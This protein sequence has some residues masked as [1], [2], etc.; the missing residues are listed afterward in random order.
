MLQ[1]VKIAFGTFLGRYFASIVA[2][3]KPL[4]AFVA[5]PLEKA[6]A[7]V[8]ARMIDA[9]EEMLALW[10][11]ADKDG[12]STSP[13]DMP[14]ML[15]AM[16]KDYVPT[17]RDFTRQVAD[18][19][20]VVLPGD[21]R[22]RMFGLRT[23]AGDVRA[24]IVVFATDEP[25]A[26]S[27]AAQFLLFLDATENR[28][29]V[30]RYRFA[31][32]DLDWPVQIETPENPAMSIQSDAKNLTILAVDVNLRVQIPLFDAPAPGQPNDGK[33]EPGT[34]DPAGYPLVQTVSVSSAEAGDQAGG[35]AEIRGYSVAD[36]GGS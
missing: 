26:R 22:G 12:R 2:T 9:A 32:L 19:E 25:S 5:R 33:G 20:M 24:Q 6:V 1:P 15:V 23:A 11:R 8:P 31:G 35:A 21:A 14:V 36:G 18:R 28:R 34:D 7:W 27:L 29:F 16:A 4:E 13:P 10:M 30:A 3:A 17:G